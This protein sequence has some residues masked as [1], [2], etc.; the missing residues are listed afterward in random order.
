MRKPAACRCSARGI[1]E[2]VRRAVVAT[3]AA[4][5]QTGRSKKLPGPRL[6]RRVPLRIRSGRRGDV[7]GATKIRSPISRRPRAGIRTSRHDQRAWACTQVRNDAGP[8][9]RVPSP[10]VGEGQGEGTRAAARR[11]L[12]QRRDV[13]TRKLTRDVQIPRAAARSGSI[14]ACRRRTPHPIPLPHTR[15]EGN[16]LRRL[17]SVRKM[18]E[19][20]SAFAGVTNSNVASSTKPCLE[21]PQLAQIAPQLL[22]RLKMQTRDAHRLGAPDIGRGIVDEH[23]VRG[24]QAETLQQMM[25]DARIRLDQAD[26]AGHHDPVEPLEERKAR[27]C[28]RKGLVRPVGE[29]V[30]RRLPPLQ[31]CKNLHRPVDRPRHH[32]LPAFPEGANVWFVVRELRR[33]NGNTLVERPAGILLAY[34]IM[35]DDGVEELLELVGIRDQ[36]FVEQP[37]V[38]S[39]QDVAEIEDDGIGHQAALMQTRSMSRRMKVSHSASC[40][41]VTHSFGLWAWSMLP[42][43]QMMA[44]MPVSWNS[45]ASVPKATLM[46]ELPPVS[47]FASSTI[48]LSTAVARPGKADSSCQVKPVSPAILCMAGC[49]VSSAKRRTSSNMAAP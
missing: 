41:S 39:D 9:Y 17:A 19:C 37:R 13:K 42:G 18:Y 40:S 32:L 48:S 47:A 2:L 38:P 30:E 35:G 46:V 45:P 25:V 36:L 49:S 12:V 14:G 43:Q 26:L 6:R 15:G 23:A 5:S 31:F 33:Q 24:R 21:Q 34:P 27:P 4:A 3:A 7:S 10:L 11:D 1:A 28:D 22:R 44:G 16:L 20:P 8:P 29:G